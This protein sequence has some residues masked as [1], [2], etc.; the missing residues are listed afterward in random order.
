MNNKALI[1]IKPHAVTDASVSFIEEFLASAGLTLSEKQIKTAQ[2]IHDQ[3]IV[4]RHYFAIAHTAVFRPPAEYI[5]TEAAKQNFFD[6]F[7][8]EWDDALDAGR[9][10]NA[11]EAQEN[12]GGVKGVEL[13][14]KWKASAQAKLAPGLYAAYFEEEDFFCINGFYP[15]QREVFTENGAKVVLWEAE[16]SPSTLSWE[17]FRAKLIGATDPAKATEGSL[18]NLLLHRWEQLGF[19][20]KPEMSKNGVHASAGPL[21]G[22]RERMVWLDTD[23]AEDEFATALIEEGVGAERLVALLENPTVKLDGREEPIFD[24]TE[25]LDADRAVEVI[26]KEIEG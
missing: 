11:V 19:S 23:A 4:D 10:L 8:V 16:F 13:N 26:A 14:E 17:S 25:D 6:A 22:L 15:G 7:D 20:A 12:L 3:G 5:M 24:L 9:I 18:R 1:F 2:E 21:E